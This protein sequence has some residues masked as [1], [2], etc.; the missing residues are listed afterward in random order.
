MRPLSI[1][2][3]LAFSSPALASAQAGAMAL[4][5]SLVGVWRQ[6]E[7]RASDGTLVSNQ[8]GIRMY[9]DGHYAIVQ[10]NGLQPREN[11][12]STATAAQLWEIFGSG[13]VGQAGTYEVDG[14]T[15]TTRPLVAKQPATMAP[16][17]FTTSN[18]RL[19]ADTLWII[20]TRNQAGAITN[21]ATS[22]YVRVR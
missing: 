4:G 15:T 22:K 16:G 18:V 8:P 17:S 21:A 12:D 14:Q 19:V 9:M 5:Q 2:V 7:A 10:V 20:P 13:F 11:R 3:L 1:L 6:V